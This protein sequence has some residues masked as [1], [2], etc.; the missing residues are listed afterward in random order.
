VNSVDVVCCAE[1]YA[2]QLSKELKQNGEAEGAEIPGDD[3][4]DAEHSTLD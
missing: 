2:F 3:S 4:L 1:L